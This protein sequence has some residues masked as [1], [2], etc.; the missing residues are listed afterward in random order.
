VSLDLLVCEAEEDEDTE[1]GK[2][3]KKG[4]KRAA[5]GPVLKHSVSE[6][7]LTC[8]TIVTLPLDAPKLLM[9]DIAERV[10]ANVY[11]RS[12]QVNRR[13]TSP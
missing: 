1:G 13:P 11:V 12:T 10:A 4:G 2:A 7:D 9:L 3:A 6:G 8:T 5:D